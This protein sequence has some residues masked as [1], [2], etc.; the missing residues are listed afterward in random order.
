MVVAAVAAVTS[1]TKMA[2]AAKKMAVAVALCGA[3]L[4]A[5][6]E[7]GSKEAITVIYCGTL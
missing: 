6:I 4:V 2:A 7:A 3:Q 1:G 5:K